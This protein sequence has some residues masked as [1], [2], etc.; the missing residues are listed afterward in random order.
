[1][2]PWISARGR[3]RRG[4]VPDRTLP[5]N[6]RRV[7]NVLVRKKKKTSIIVRDKKKGVHGYESSLVGEK[8]KREKKRALI[9]PPGLGGRV[10][11]S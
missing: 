9:R 3:K 4:K 1:V 6:A 2:F 10:P 8:G 5:S 11:L 7:K